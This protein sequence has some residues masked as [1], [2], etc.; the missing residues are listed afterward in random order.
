GLVIAIIGEEH[1]PSLRVTLI[2]SDQRKA[3]F[4]RTVIRELGL[5]RVEVIDARIEAADPQEADVLSAR[6]LAPL[7]RLLG[8]AERHLSPGGI[9]L[10]PKGARYADEVNRALASWRFEVQNHPS[11]TDPQAVVLKLGGIARV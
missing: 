5:K 9:A 7:D 10:F 11:K 1:A 3:T 6:A 8:F 2:E 4:L